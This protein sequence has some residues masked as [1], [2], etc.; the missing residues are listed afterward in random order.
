[1]LRVSCKDIGIEGCDFSCEAEKAG[2]LEERVFDHIRAQHPE[3]IAGLD[4]KQHRELERRMRSAIAPE[5]AN[6]DDEVA[7]RSGRAA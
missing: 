4:W 5:R 3:L 2:K 1:M 6:A 7:P